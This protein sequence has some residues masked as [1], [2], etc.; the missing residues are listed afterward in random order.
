MQLTYS[1]DELIRNF[2][3][4][5]ESYGFEQELAILDI[6]RHQFM[7]KK[8]AM[9]EFVPLFIALW[10]LALAKSFPD[11]A[12]LYYE[13]FL[14][15]HSNVFRGSQKETAR[16]LQ[17]IEVYNTLMQEKK[18][19]DFSAIAAFCTDKLVTD[20]SKRPRAT[21]KMA[22]AIRAMYNLVFERLI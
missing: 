16:H 9:K 18:D 20:D 7:R 6:K 22:L 10:K 4:I 15:R 13:A 12:E 8:A 2:N 1:S 19:G 21:L 17:R 3:A 14:S 11:E 5:L